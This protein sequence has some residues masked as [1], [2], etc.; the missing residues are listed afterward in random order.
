MKM[1]LLALV[2][3]I[4]KGQTMILYHSR[5]MSV[6]T[7]APLEKGILEFSSYWKLVD[8]VTNLTQLM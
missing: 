6:F 7:A 5:T 1:K 8:I 2:T 4:I 3:F